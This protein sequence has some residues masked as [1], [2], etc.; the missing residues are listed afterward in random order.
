VGLE[1]P[2]PPDAATAHGGGRSGR[3]LSQRDL[4]RALLERQML[5]RRWKLSAHEAIERLVGM[6]A[7]VPNDP[8]FGLWTRLEGFHPDQL[9]Q[10][11]NDRRALRMPLMRATIH[12]VTAR[13]CLALRPLVQ[14]VQERTLNNTAFGRGTVGMDTEA[15]LAA[16]QALLEE[17][18]R[19]LTELGKLLNTRWPDRDPVNLARAIHY[20]AALVQ[21][22]PRGVWGASGQ[23]TWTTVEAWLG[24]PLDADP[25]LDQMVMRYLAAFGPATVRDMQTWSGLTGLRDVIK[26]IRPRLLTLRNERGR[27]MFDLPEA[28]RPDPDTP[29]PPRFLPEYEYDNVFLSHAD[30]TRIIADHHRTLLTTKNGVGPSTFLIDGFIRGTWKINWNRTTA[31]LLIN[32]LDPLPNPDRSALAEEGAQLLKFAAPDAQAHEVQFSAPV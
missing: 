28:P 3:V 21:V 8:Y 19:T 4:N 15:L 2:T 20:R 22:P 30:R 5:L 9:V 29:A 32:P 26:R 25:S 13:D 31:T 6:Q 18:P 27:E 1:A 10:L 11:I 16:G 14:S 12:L 17:K 23:A 24:R 7:Q